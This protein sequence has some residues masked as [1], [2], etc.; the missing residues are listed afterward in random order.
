[1]WIVDRGWMMGE[2]WAEEAEARWVVDR[3]GMIAHAC[4]A[5]SG[6][7]ERQHW[8]R[9][10]VADPSCAPSSVGSERFPGQV[11]PGVVKLLPN[12]TNHWLCH[13][14]LEAATPSARAPPREHRA[15]RRLLHCQ[16]QQ[17]LLRWRP[18]HHTT[19]PLHL[20]CQPHRY[21]QHWIPFACRPC[22]SLLRHAKSRTRCNRQVAAN[23][24]VMVLSHDRPRRL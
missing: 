16:E 22:V 24:S 17:A 20:R 18:F 10:D 19:C 9:N 12:Q 23:H 1:M 4:E 21:S 7:P 2:A 11:P 5:T 15:S 8:H 3:G 6:L 14:Q 13:Q